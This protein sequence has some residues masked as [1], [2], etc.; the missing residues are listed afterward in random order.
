[1]IPKA[2]RRK[3]YHIISFIYENERDFLNQFMDNGFIDIIDIGISSESI[4]FTA[5]HDCGQH[6]S[7]SISIDMYNQWFFSF[8][9]EIRANFYHNLKGNKNASAEK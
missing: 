2:I 6:V 9:K 1:M 3:L 4:K 8:P 7:N 5:V